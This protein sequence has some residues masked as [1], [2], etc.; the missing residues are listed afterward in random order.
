MSAR[1]QRRIWRLSIPVVLIMAVGMVISSLT[2]ADASASPSSHSSIRSHTISAVTPASAY[3]CVGN[4][5]TNNVRTCITIGGTGRYVTIMVGSAYIRNYT[6]VGHIQLYGPNG[7]SKNYP[8][9]GTIL[10]EVGFQY[11]NVWE[12]RKDEPAGKY[13]AETWSPNGSGGYK[14]WGSAC[15]T[16]I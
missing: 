2:M 4:P 3:G 14:S 11:T 1:R 6:I 8:A 10:M 7:F 5:P 12:P 16:V 9:S 13:C 15:K